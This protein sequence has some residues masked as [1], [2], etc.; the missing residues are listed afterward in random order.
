MNKPKKAPLRGKKF[1]EILQIAASQGLIDEKVLTQSEINPI[2]L[3]KD[4]MGDYVFKVDQDSNTLYYYVEKE[5]IYSDKTEQLIKREIA[6]RLDENFKA[7]YYA[8][9]NGYITATANLV[10]MNEQAPEIFAMKNGILNTV[11]R[12]LTHYSPNVHETTKIDTVYD[13]N[14]N[15]SVSRN[16]K[17]LTQVVPNSIQRNQIQELAGHILIRK[18]I[19]ETT[20][21]L[22]GKKG[23]NGKSIFLDMLKKLLGSDNVSSKTIQNLCYD[24]FAVAELR[25][26]LVNIFADLPH[27]EILDTAIFRALVTGDSIA[28]AVKHVQGKGETMDPTTKYLFSANHLPPIASEED[29]YAWYRR[30]IF[31][32]FPLTF[33]P[34]KNARPRQELLDELTTPYEKSAV[35]NWALDGLAQLLKN[36]DI[37]NKPAVEEIRKEYRKRS[38]TTLAFFD[39]QVIVTDNK[40]DWT[41][42]NDWF[43]EYVTYCH[44]R[45]LTPKSKGEFIK[46]IEQY[47]PGVKDTKIRPEPKKSPISAWRYVKVVPYVP[48]VPHSENIEPLNGKNTIDISHFS[49]KRFKNVEQTEHMEQV[50]SL[51]LVPIAAIC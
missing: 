25:N 47:L 18:I 4:I 44:D 8:E 21:V 51:P 40:D 36:G 15:Y 23:G 28:V 22:I 3:A 5:G 39:D 46:D 37:S 24:K 16:C 7:R 45:D 34:G 33:T 29:C 38:S 12:E 35:L 19:T 50:E 10:R 20:G 32:D 9:I 1:R 17:F 30:F 42:T 27:K 14:K 48:R 31:V 11:T 13:P 26:K 49:G 6:K 41:F 2:I 43:R